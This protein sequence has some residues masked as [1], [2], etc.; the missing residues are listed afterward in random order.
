MC[1]FERT[2]TWEEREERNVYETELQR[3][4]CYL[5]KEHRLYVHI[6]MVSNRPLVGQTGN[7]I[8]VHNVIFMIGF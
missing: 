1:L 7:N 2:G 5:K 3:P 8:C 6:A 4:A